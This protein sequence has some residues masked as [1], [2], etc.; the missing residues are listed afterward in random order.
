[1]NELHL[2]IYQVVGSACGL[3]IGVLLARSADQRLPAVLVSAPVAIAMLGL[4]VAPQLALLWVVIAAA[5]AGS[6]LTVALALVVLRTRTSEETAALSGMAQSVGY[7]IAFS[8]P[9]AAGL[10]VDRV[11]WTPLLIGVAGVAVA[12]TGLALWAGQ[13]THVFGWVEEDHVAVS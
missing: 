2:V 3:A 10:L 11:G 8:G 9:L 7:L 12:Q 13:P 1:M 4:V 6:S 5:G